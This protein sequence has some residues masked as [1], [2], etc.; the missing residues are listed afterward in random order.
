MFIEGAVT[1]FTAAFLHKVKP[2]ILEGTALDASG[3]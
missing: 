1:G 2:E 3:Y